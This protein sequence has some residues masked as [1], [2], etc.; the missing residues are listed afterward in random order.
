MAASTT[1][2]LVL[3]VVRIFEPANGYQL[4]RE[5]LSWQVD[6]WANVKP[7]SIYSMLNTLHGA[8]LIDRHELTDETGHKDIAVYT[9]TEAGH[10]ELQ[11]L[12]GQ[13]VERVA[14]MDAA[15]FRAGMS[16]LP[17]VTRA[18]FLQLLGRRAQNLDALRVDLETKLAVLREQQVAP[19]HVAAPVELELRL[20]RTEI[21]WLAEFVDTV[22]SGALQF[23]GEP[24]DGWVPLPDDPGWPMVRQ[25]A[26]YRELLGMPARWG[27][28]GARG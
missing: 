20:V 16:L 9:M 7:G 18:D 11:M 24:D 13:A 12:I 15:G 19:P 2:L 26:R 21:D 22:T 10:A 8:G 25:N 3:G 5:L 23:L 4:R 17:F 14:V 1:R 27:T 6:A 28:V